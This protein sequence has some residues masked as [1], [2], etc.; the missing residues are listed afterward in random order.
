[1][2]ET[3]DISEANTMVKKVL[4][5]IVNTE[6]V[7]GAFIASNRSEVIGKRDLKYSDGQLKELS[8]HILRMIAA[9]HLAGKATS[10]LEFYW[11]NQYIICKTSDH[12]IVVTFC[13]SANILAFVRITLN[14]T[15]ATLLEDKKFSKW[16][17]THVAAK[18]FV[19]RKGQLNE[20]E[21]RLV[22][23]LKI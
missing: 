11:Q 17:R 10:E 20:E 2:V 21:T 16:L 23:Q 7:S 1:M 4:N 5:E 6:G 13:N 14:V 9:F 3:G 22:N 12:F 19:L 8:I 15:V 18:D